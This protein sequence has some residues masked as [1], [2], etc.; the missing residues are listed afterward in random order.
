MRNI[1]LLGLLSGAVMASESGYYVGAEV[2]RT[3]TK[4]A[5]II[6]GIED[7]ASSN[8]V[9]EGLNLGIYLN[10]NNRVYLAYQ[11]V[12]A[13]SNKEIPATTNI[14]SIGYDYLYGSS[15][16]KPFVGAIIGYSTYKDGTFKVDGMA[17]GAQVGIDYKIHDN[18]AVDIGYRYLDS[19]AKGTNFSGGESPI[20][21]YQ[22]FFIAA[23]YKF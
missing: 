12:N 16:L 17:Y 7:K 10:E 19:D 5:D 1:V 22:T 11:H 4:A 13:D 6:S 15:T 21:S 18:I 23:N 14:Y 2:G 9:S 3:H 8:R 20:Y